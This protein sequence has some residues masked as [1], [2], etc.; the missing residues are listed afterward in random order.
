V[1][2]RRLLGSKSQYF[3]ATI[4][5]PLIQEYKNLPPATPFKLRV[6]LDDCSNC[7]T[8]PNNNVPLIHVQE[9][10]F[11]DTL[12]QCTP[13][14][15]NSQN[16]HIFGNGGQMVFPVIRREVNELNIPPSS[17]VTFNRAILGT[18]P[19]R[20][21]MVILPTDAWRQNNPRKN[22]YIYKFAG[23]TNMTLKYGDK[24]WPKKGGI[25][26]H[27]VPNDILS[28]TEIK[29]LTDEEVDNLVNDNIEA[30]DIMRKVF[31]ASN[32]THK[33]AVKEREWFKYCNVLGVDF[34]PF[35]QDFLNP[36]VREPITEGDVTIRLS[37]V[38]PFPPGH[39]LI[40][41]SEFKNTVTWSLPDFGLKGDY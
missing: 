4:L 3:S 9:A 39:K 17:Q 23:I 7:F 11:E 6:V 22:P 32:F 26:F 29:T 28:D 5:H 13:E 24:E 33:L 12:I 19:S 36:D 27:S 37:F 30:Y 34:T 14:F 41:I 10:Y 40:L 25:D 1:Y 38:K 18:I 21:F 20:L 35:Q 31:S 15:I 2:S 8:C 16:K